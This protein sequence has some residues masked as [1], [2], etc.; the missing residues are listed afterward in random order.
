MAEPRQD[1]RLVGLKEFQRALKAAG[2]ASGKEIGAANHKVA[3]KVVEWARSEAR[4]QKGAT[5]K[6]A[7]DRTALRATRKQKAASVVIN[8]SNERLRGWA[9]GAEFGS[10]QFAQFKPWR[11]N[12]FDI[13]GSGPGYALH[14]AIREH[15]DDIEDMYFDA[16]DELAKAFPD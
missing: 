1:V 13:I 16:L 12:Q 7:S 5:G 4:G 9:L 14:P 8:A 3:S 15:I 6:L 10:L 11:G 2:A